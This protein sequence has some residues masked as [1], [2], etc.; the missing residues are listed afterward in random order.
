[1]EVEVLLMLAVLEPIEQAI[2]EFVDVDAEDEVLVGEEDKRG[3][4]PDAGRATRDDDDLVV[5]HRVEHAAGGGGD[6]VVG[7]LRLEGRG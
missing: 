6:A 3:L 4:E 5:A 1:M 2:V 7:T